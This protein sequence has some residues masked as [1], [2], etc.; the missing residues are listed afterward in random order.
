MRKFFCLHAGE[1]CV[2]LSLSSIYMT[3][4]REFLAGLLGIAALP[5]VAAF[6]KA[7]RLSSEDELQTASEKEATTTYIYGQMVKRA[8][9]ERWTGLS[10]G[11]LMGN[12]GTLLVGTKYV[13]GTLEGAGPEVCRA[14]FTGLDCVTFFENVLCMA[15]VLKKGNA[16]FDAFMRELTLTRYRDGQ[17]TDY[18]SRLHYTAEW[19]TNNVQKGVVRD[20]TAQIGGVPLPINVN[21]MS[22]HPEY[23]PA[24]KDSP[25]MVATMAAI[26]QRINAQ[27]L[28]YI[29][30]KDIKSAQKQLQTGDIVAIATNKTGLDYSHTGM[31]YVD[32]KGKTRFLHA[33]LKKKK[34]F[35]DTELHQYVKSVKSNIGVSVL[36]PLEV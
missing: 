31:I 33:S 9:Q 19:I 26:E 3:T 20:I 32:K 25:S 8:V 14:D 5:A 34:V 11:L 28:A 27:P 30:V 13:G 15:R 4:R 35:L 7:G 16:A 17:L 18:T 10:I 29:P 24:L 36:R 21:F 2:R 12:L 1:D 6:A 23:Y 22:Q